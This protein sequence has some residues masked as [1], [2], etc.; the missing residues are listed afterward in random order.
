M[1]IA[2]PVLQI[3]IPIKP[4]EKVEKHPFSPSIPPV[5]IRTNFI[6]IFLD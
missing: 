1:S 6:K 3:I 4:L 2:F 5:G